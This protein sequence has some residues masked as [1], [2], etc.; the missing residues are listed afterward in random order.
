M[1]L[2]QFVINRYHTKQFRNVLKTMTAMAF[3]KIVG[4]ISNT[5]EIR[6]NSWV[7]LGQTKGVMGVAG[8]ALRNIELVLYF[9]GEVRGAP[10]QIDARDI[11]KQVGQGHEYDNKNLTKKRKNANMIKTYKK[12]HMAN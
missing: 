12:Y 9:S 3:A 1:Q 11:L 2:N 5:P 4:P 10:L 7:G 6:E 8:Q